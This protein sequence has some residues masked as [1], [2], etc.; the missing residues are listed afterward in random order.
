MAGPQAKPDSSLPSRVTSGLVG[1]AVLLGVVYDGRILLFLALIAILIIGSLELRDMLRNRG[2]ELNMGFLLVGGVVM[3][4]FSLPQL[5]DV[6]P[7]IPWR[8]IALGLV[9]IGAFSN[10]LIAG[11]NIERFAYS[12]MAFLYL[13]WTLGFFLLLRHQPNG[14]IGLW[15][16]TLPLLCSLANDVGAYFVGRFFG[17]HKLAPTISPGKTVEGSIGGIVISFLVLWGYTSIMANAYPGSPFALFDPL[18]LSIINLLLSF[19]AQ[20][21]DLTESMLKRY[22]GVKDSG[23]LLPGHGG[24]LDRLDSHLFTVPLTY[25]LLSL[26]LR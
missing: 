10:E 1:F 12:L 15:V 23:S 9:L 21:G 20:L 26:L 17:R 24:L 7:G 16:L 4:L 3:L 6:Y 22:C 18:R 19:A 2:I 11:G 25:Y 14:D 5:Y 8:E 13:P